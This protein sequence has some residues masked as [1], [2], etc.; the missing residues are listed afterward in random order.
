MKLAAVIGVH[1]EHE[2]IAADRG[3]GWIATLAALAVVAAFLFSLE[4]AH[5]YYFLQ[6]DNRDMTLPFYALAARTL[7]AGDVAQ[8]NFFQ[9]LGTPLLATGQAGVLNPAVYLAIAGSRVLFGHV[10]AA[11]DLLVAA[12]FVA[13]AAGM[14]F[15]ASGLG[16][17]VSTT[18]TITGG[19]VGVGW[20]NNPGQV[21]WRVALRIIWAWLFTIQ[22]AAIIAAGIYGLLGL[23]GISDSV[24]GP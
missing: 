4:L 17:P 11:I 24:Q 7:A 13:G 16:V 20:V 5:P 6:D 10:F 3:I 15:L 23:L 8:Y 12:Y 18:H 14:L 19:I 2:T 1:D 22:S 21:R 9:A